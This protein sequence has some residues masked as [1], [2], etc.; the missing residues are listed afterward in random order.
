MTDLL[1]YQLQFYCPSFPS[2]F[3][4]ESSST[5]VF[6]C[7]FSCLVLYHFIA[8]LAFGTA[9]FYLPARVFSLLSFSVITSASVSMAVVFPCNLQSVIFQGIKLFVWFKLMVSE[10]GPYLTPEK[11]TKLMKWYQIWIWPCICSIV[12]PYVHLW[13][14][15]ILWQP[16]IIL[17][18]MLVI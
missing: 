13:V 5:S 3:F 15:P 6:L 10:Y 14:K 12:N 11:S 2:V 16:F 18:H 17:F 4:S 7:P 9:T 8:S 1:T